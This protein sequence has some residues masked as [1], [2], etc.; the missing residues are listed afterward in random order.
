MYAV[1]LAGGEGTR[2][3]PL[4]R[5]DRPK[6]F[7]PL[8]GEETL[9]Q[10]TVRRLLE[11]PELGIRA[12]DVYVVVD[13][14]FA[15]LA[16]SQR[17]DVTVVEEPEG[18][19]TAPAI[20]L[21]TL[22][23]DRPDDEVMVVLPA[24]H[25]IE[26][27]A[28]YRSLLLAAAE[29]LAPGAFG[30]ES[31]LVTLGV[32]IDRPATEYGYLIPDLARPGG[33]RLRA[34]PLLR[35]EEKPSRE[36][37]EALMDVPGAAW[38]AG[39][40]LWRRRAIR[41]AFETFAPDILATVR[42]GLEGD[43]LDEAYAAVR[44]TSIDYAVMEPAAAAGRVVMGVLDVGWNDLGSWEALLRALD[45]V[46]T[47]RVVEPNEPAEAGPDDLVVEPEGDRLVVSAGPRRILAPSATALLVGARESRP[48]VE[49]LIARASLR[50]A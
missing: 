41:R 48:I 28:T 17:P 13:R 44:R 31:P 20:A 3:R 46:G 18:R 37:A 30:V 36:R 32:A 42:R 22:A 26:R 39:M 8:L 43:R 19:N 24:D 40:F 16:R 45:G 15:G 29:E 33:Q 25:T 14:R 9:F 6:P 21:A 4:S 7:L 34:Y 12:S 47:G 5:P 1:I 49:A 23:I 11:G 38:N 27:E 35:F 50:E 10:R 2:L